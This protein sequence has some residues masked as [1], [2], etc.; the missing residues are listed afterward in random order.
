MGGGG[1][2]NTN[3][4]TETRYAPY[5]EAKHEPFLVAGVETRESIIGSSPYALYTAPN[6]DD[7]FFSLGFIL[8]S[9]PS[10][11]D[12]FGKTMAG[13]DIDSLF[14]NNF[15]GKMADTESVI[16]SELTLIDDAI[17]QEQ[18]H[19]TTARELNATQGSPFIIVNANIEKDRIKK[20]TELRLAAKYSLIPGVVNTWTKT[21]NWKKD[22]IV[23]YAKALQNYY[24]CKINTDTAEYR[25]KN[26]NTS[27]PL[28]V[29][30]FERSL[31]AA[32]LGTRFSR[33]LTTKERSDI[34]KALLVAS[35][36]AQGAQLG[37]MV[38]GI[39]IVAG[40]VIGFVIGIA[41]VLME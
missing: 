12:T 31:Y 6:I 37:F 29:L 23:E 11:Y 14:T 38:S 8:S 39:G 7:G 25:K 9:F 13:L 16:K 28:T 17:D 24:L 33:S 5:I 10:L 40:G 34:S 27:W 3:T 2:S 19:K 41:I 30:D 21:L 18:T 32:M 15:S 1:S 36:T 4:I 35:Y 20:T 22:T 26:E